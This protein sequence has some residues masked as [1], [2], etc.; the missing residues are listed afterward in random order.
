MKILCFDPFH[1]ASGDMIVGALLDLGVPLE[2]VTEPLEKLLPGEFHAQTRRVLR[3][4]VSAGKFDVHVADSASGHGHGH[5]HDH[6]HSHGHGARRHLKE[7]LALA[8]HDALPV[9]VRRQAARCFTR[10]C[11]VEASIHGSTPEKVHLHEAGGVDSIVDVIGALLAIDHLAPD[12]ILTLPVGLGHGSIHIAHGTVPVPAPATLRLLHGFPTRPGAWG[13]ERPDSAELC[14]PT[15]AVLLTTLCRPTSALPAMSVQAGGFG[16]GTRDDVGV[17]NVLRAVVGEA[18]EDTAV[19]PDHIWQIECVLDDMPGE[20]LGYLFERLEQ[21]G[22][23]EVSTQAVGL[24]K[25][26]PGVLLRALAS[27][28]HKAD[29]SEALFSETTTFG[30]RYYPVQR[31]VLERHHEQV[32]TPWGEVR[33]KVGRDAGGVVTASPE[34]E[35]CRRR[36]SEAGVPLRRVFEAARNAWH[37]RE[38]TG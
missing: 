11:E 7:L 35:D 28:E 15:G 16:A 8:E 10:L 25:S 6:G 13:P 22:A 17:P 33:I 18:T 29:V 20:W 31:D 32:S 1:G 9:G 26:R 4:G 34:Y 37:S 3:Q 36:A 38:H 21:A 23:L 27:P 2:V 14:T 5:H 24:K 19:R 12:R 30:L